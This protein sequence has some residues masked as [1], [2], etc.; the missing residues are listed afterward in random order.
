MEQRNPDWGLQKVD[1]WSRRRLIPGEKV[2][3]HHIDG[4]HE[5]WRSSNLIALHRACHH[6]QEI[7]VSSR[8]GTTAGAV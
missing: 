6:N 5:N 8:P 1:S 4:N 3:L 7:H 2:E